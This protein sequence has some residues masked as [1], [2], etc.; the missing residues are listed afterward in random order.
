MCARGER[1]ALTTSQKVTKKEI[2]DIYRGR[3]AQS[4]VAAE[5]VVYIGEVQQGGVVNF[6]K[7]GKRVVDRIYPLSTRPYSVPRTVPGFLDREQE[8]GAVGQALARRQLVDLHGPHGV[9]KTALVSQ[10]LI[11][12]PPG[13][14]P[15]GIV[16]LSAGHD[17]YEDL[18][19]ELFKHFFEIERGV[20][21]TE[22][23]VR[24]YMTGKYALIAIDDANNLGE[25]K[26]EALTGALPHCAVLVA[27]SD[28][29]VWQAVGIPLGGLPWT[30]AVAL[31]ERS[32]GPVSPQ[33]RP[34]VE[35]IC[36]ALNGIPLSILKSATIA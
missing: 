16:Y 26:A 35:A 24:R 7:P 9:G 23:D 14:F 33:D 34:A 20:K 8:L 1:A 11:T 2:R 32:W 18:L 4:V 30:H 36:Q 21:V 12:L 29:Q 5:Y 19:Q 3:H 27:G 13:S 28:Q 10:T 25:R 31:F 22:S 15:D 17:G 6:A